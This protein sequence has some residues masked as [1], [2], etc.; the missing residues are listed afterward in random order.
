MRPIEDIRGEILGSI[1]SN[2]N[3]TAPA[4]D[5]SF[6]RV[7][8][9]A[10]AGES[11][12]IELL[13]ETQFD[14]CDPYTALDLT[15]WARLVNRPREGASSCVAVIRVT[16]TDGLQI[17]PDI[18]G[19]RWSN[20]AGDLYYC[21]VGGTIV[22]GF[23]DITVR[24]LEPGEDKNLTPSETLTMTNP[25]NGLD[26]EST[27]QSIT[28]FAVAEESDED[29]RREIIRR[30][31]N[32]RTAGGPADYY[33]TA[34]AVEN[35]I[36]AFPYAG[37]VPGQ[38]R[39]WIV[40]SD[41]PDGI[42]TTGQLQ[43]VCDAIL[44]AP[45][46]PLWSRDTMPDGSPRILCLASPVTG[47]VV[48]ITGL[49]PNTTVLRSAIETRITQFFASRRPYVFGL[50]SIIENRIDRNDLR[51]IVQLAIN[52][53]G[54]GSFADLTVALDSTPGSPFASYALPE[55][56]RAKVTTLAFS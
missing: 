9:T 25:Q 51:A 23:V 39:S 28:S 30:I 15:R 6:V 48:T 32:P 53:S 18:N 43:A 16:G 14:E 27:V 19:I 44:S 8:S 4:F 46:L 38:I 56:T 5:R 11:A 49:S 17:A 22:G 40:V 34:T 31:N 42:P 37:N 35:V 24:S 3:Q 52:S 54:G 21:T 7:M 50:S 41:Q 47:F 26:R 45:W 10:Q 20:G 12:Q 2:L 55:G 13:A 36:D 29:W 33:A 1:E